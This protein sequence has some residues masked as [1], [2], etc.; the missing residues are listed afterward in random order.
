MQ[1]RLESM[2]K[3]G[4]HDAHSIYFDHLMIEIIEI[5]QDFGLFPWLER[6]P[7]V[8]D[9]DQNDGNRNRRNAPNP[10]NARL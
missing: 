8:S 1:K 5:M 6:E 9:R 7:S 2:L 3:S 4:L 10:F